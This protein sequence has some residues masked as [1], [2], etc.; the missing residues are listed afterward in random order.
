LDI[1]QCPGG[2]HIEDGQAAYDVRPLRP[3]A[4]DARRSE[5]SMNMFRIFLLSMA[6][7]GANAAAVAADLPRDPEQYFFD[8]T[9]GEFTEELATARSEGKKGIMLFF[10]EA[11][12]P[13][14]HRM[15]TTVFNQP[16]VQD[17]FR[18]NFLIFAMDTKSGA[19]VTDFQGHQTTQKALFSK[20]T[21]NRGATPVMAF[22]DLNG[23]LVVRYTGATSG[24]DEFM[25]LGQY[26]ADGLYKKLP[27]TKYKREKRGEL[28][29]G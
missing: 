20:I 6:F 12:C 23:K 24:V 9:L 21:H 4:G 14:C 29:G 5:E 25:W 17:Y 15:K 28:N 16:Q 1:E 26:A 10:E 3:L 11:D 18:K 19:E 2:A 8:T 22:F 7:L 13:F 27:F